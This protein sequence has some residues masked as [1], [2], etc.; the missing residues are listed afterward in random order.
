MSCA[1]KARLGLG[2][3]GLLVGSAQA[4]TTEGEPLDVRQALSRDVAVNWT[5]LTVEVTSGARG[6]GVT[7]TTKALEHTARR[8]IGPDITW[9]ARRVRVATDVTVDDLRHDPELGD[10]VEARIERW[11]VSEARYYTSGRVEL[12]GELSLQELLKPWALSVALLAP[13]QEGRRGY[14]G[15]V[16]DARGTGATP[17]YAPR[18]LHGDEVLYSGAMWDDVALFQTPVV[19]V[20]DPAHPAAARAGEK[21]LVVRAERAMETDLVIGDEDFIRFRTG[22]H[23]VR[24]LGEGTVVVVLDW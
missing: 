10:A 8:K 12:T 2:T 23:D 4:V 17:A 11:V 19:Y 13:E 3:L 24:V 1:G 16:V 15:L 5:R 14:T 21:P 9:G 18:I 20:P 6:W 22:F 7:A